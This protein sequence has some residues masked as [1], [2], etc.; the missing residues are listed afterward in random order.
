MVPPTVSGVEGGFVLVEPIQA[1]EGLVPKALRRA[2]PESL[3]VAPGDITPA[4]GRIERFDAE[5]RPE[6]DRRSPDPLLKDLLAAR[7]FIVNGST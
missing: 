5:D 4:L 7:E 1:I 6:I 2:M 3:Q